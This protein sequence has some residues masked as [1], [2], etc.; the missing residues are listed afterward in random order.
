LARTLADHDDVAALWYFGS[1]QG[2]AAVEKA[3][4]GNLKA[5]W[6]SNGKRRDWFDRQQ[7]QGHEYLRRAVQIKN[8]WIPYG[9]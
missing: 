9:E 7:G 2:S 6:V 1:K 3:S 4:S 8:I 5:T